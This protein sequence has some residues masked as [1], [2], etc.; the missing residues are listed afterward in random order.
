MDSVHFMKYSAQHMSLENEI[1]TSP[2]FIH[3]IYKDAKQ[4]RNVNEDLVPP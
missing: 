2:V 4:N 3:V 1:Q